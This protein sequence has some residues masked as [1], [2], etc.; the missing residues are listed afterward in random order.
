MQKLTE[1]PENLKHLIPEYEIIL[2]F[3]K[4]AIKFPELSISQSIIFMKYL[5][6]FINKYDK[7]V[8]ELSQK[9]EN[10]NISAFEIL[11]NISDSLDVENHFKNMFIEMFPGLTE[12]EVNSMTKKQFI[13]N[14][15]ELYKINFTIKKEAEEIGEE[16]MEILPVLKI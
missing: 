14:L 2:L 7:I 16:I 9:E 12:E 10:K 15:S 8:S 11:L 1:I 4:N 6:S 5:Y 13:Y 3:G